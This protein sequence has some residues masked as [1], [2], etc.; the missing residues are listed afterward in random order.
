M[1]DKVR[2]LNHIPHEEVK[3]YELDGRYDYFMD[4]WH[5]QQG[6]LKILILC[7]MIQVLY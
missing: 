4:L 6:Q 3:L 2:L 1:K 5:I 7:I